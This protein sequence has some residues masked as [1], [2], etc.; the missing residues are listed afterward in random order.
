MKR[1]SPEE[2]RHARRGAGTVPVTVSLSPEVLARLDA[3]A[4]ARGCSRSA[5]VAELVTA[6]ESPARR[7]AGGA[8]GLRIEVGRRV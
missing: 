2:L 6:H 4:S 7:G 1:R 5:V 3:I 8:G